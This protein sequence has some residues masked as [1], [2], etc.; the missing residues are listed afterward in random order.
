MSQLLIG[1]SAWSDH[2]PFY[3]PGLKSAE[4]LPYYSR[5]FPIVEVNMTYYRVPTR[6]MVENWVSRTPDHF[7]FDVKP[8]RE[9]T[10]TPETPRGE[11]PVP[12]A[13][14]ASAFADAIEPLAEVR[15][16]WRSDVPISAVVSQY[17][18]ASGVHS[19][20]AGAD[21]GIAHLG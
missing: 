7:T 18:R 10:S 9:L 3:P 4:Q 19:A 5:Y 6:K 14:V 1:T 13:D 15:Q 16:A 17:R 8:P 20:P 12:D 21:A 2:D 11:A